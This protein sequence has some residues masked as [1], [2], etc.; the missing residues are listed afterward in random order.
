MLADGT[1]RR[2]ASRRVLGT[3]IDR[4]DWLARRLYDELCGMHPDVRAWHFQWLAT[5]RL[6]RSLRPILAELRGL[7]LDVGCGKKPYGPWM[8]GVEKG[9]VV[10]IDVNPGPGVD[11]A[12]GDTGPW[13]F[14]ND[15]FDA[16]LCTQVLEHVLDPDATLREI[17]RV[18][19]PEGTL[20][21]TI[22]FLYHEHGAP[23][24]FRRFS[25]QEAVRLL[26]GRFVIEESRKAGAFG[27]TLCTMFLSWL[28]TNWDRHAAGRAAKLPLLPFW[29]AATLIVNGA[30]LF[31]DAIDGTG[32]Y[33][34]DVL[35]VARK[36]KHNG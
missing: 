22:P 36:S 7:V 27:S 17:H 24:D 20:V 34:G 6:H 26:G 13:P 30:G 8:T 23:R 14:P 9:R 15:T 16:A 19:A 18:L 2:K 33:Y 21:L 29:M 12:V 31:L 32:A 35:V 4:L 10:G 3:L 5:R 11:V 28:W 25:L 1:A